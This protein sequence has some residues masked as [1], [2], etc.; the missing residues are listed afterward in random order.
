[1]S[2]EAAAHK[3]TPAELRSAGLWM[4]PDELYHPESPGREAGCRLMAAIREGQR[5]Q[6]VLH[7]AGTVADPDHLRTAARYVQS[8]ID[9]IR[10]QLDKQG[11]AQSAIWRHRAAT[12]LRYRCQLRRK[13]LHRA[14]Q[15]TE[16]HNR[17][18]KK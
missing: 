12:S 13:L 7:I 18:T 15:L 5:N 2:N 9:D 4:H 16:Q 1:M 6:E 8:I 11:C 3:P 10:L 14:D 17:R